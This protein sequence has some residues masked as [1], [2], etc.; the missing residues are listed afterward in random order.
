MWQNN[1]FDIMAS[2]Y[3]VSKNLLKLASLSSNPDHL[4]LVLAEM[5]PTLTS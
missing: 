2:I 1:S 5:T 4:T 3:G